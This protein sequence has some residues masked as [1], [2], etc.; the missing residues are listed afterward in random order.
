M[1]GS[2]DPCTERHSTVYYNRPEVQRSLHANVTSIN[3]TWSTCSDTINDHWEDSPRSMLPI[4]KE[5]IAAHL[6]I[7]VFSSLCVALHVT[8]ALKQ[9]GGWSHVYQGLTLVVIRGA[10]HEVP[11]HRPR[12]ALIL[13]QHF[14]HG[15]PMPSVPTNGSMM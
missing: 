14:L 4:Y 1:R 8:V 2:Y 13:F 6:R 7:W 9:V 5:L 3:Y 15:K 11:L 12:R 10:G